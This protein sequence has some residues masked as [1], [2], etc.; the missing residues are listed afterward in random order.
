MSSSAGARP[1]AAD[2]GRIAGSY[3]RLRP[4][5]ERWWEVF[6]LLVTA[7]DLAGRRTLDVGCGTGTLAVA[8]A[9][10]GAKVWGVDASQE[11][12]AEA[13][14]KGSRARFKEAHAEEL[15]FKDGWFERVVMRLSLHH[16]DRP[17]ALR[18][19][20]RVLAPGGRIVVGTFDPDQF[21]DY[22]LTRYFPSIATIDAARFPDQET[23]ERELGAAGFAAPT[24]A[25]LDQGARLSRTEALERI[26]CRYISTLRLMSEEEF[27]RGLA[28]AEADLPAEVGYS[29]KWLVV[30][31]EKA[32]LDAVRPPG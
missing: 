15:P 9:E 12:L 28:V 19:A 32:P 13:Q 5:D 3:D 25:R 1:A 14:A 31:A 24:S 8:L 17:R 11:M 18:E 10:R 20:G 22:W 16:L 21:A 2:F 29:V 30:A 7:G 27:E 26:R 23:L 6:E 4:V